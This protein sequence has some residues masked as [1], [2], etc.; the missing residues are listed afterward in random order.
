MNDI[1][2]SIRSLIKRPGFVAVAVI[3]LALGIGANTA[4]FSVI[5]AVVLR[6]LP[7]ADPDR[8]VMVWETVAGNDRRSVAP[9][10]YVDWRDQNKT[11]AGMSAAF[12]G[13]FNL[14]GD[15]EP[16]RIDG[17]TITSNLM[18]VLGVPAQV[19]RTFQPVD[20][21][22]RGSSVVLIS[23][24]LWKGR[25]G[26]DHNIIGR[27][28]TIDET[29]HTVV[30]V[31]P[32]GFQF[33][34][35]SDLWVLGRD[36]NAVSLSLIS[37]FPENDWT[38]ERDAHF[39]RVVGRL[40][41]DTSLSQ[42]Q[43][44]IAG[45]ALRAEQDFPKTNAGLGSA[46]VSLHSQVVGKVQG[47]LFILFGAVAFVLLIACTNVA[48]LMLARSVKREREIAIRVAVG[49]GR[50]RLVRQLLTESFLLSLSGG[51]AG[52]LLSTW[53]VALFIKLSPGDI[54]RLDEATVD[55]RLLA[56]TFVISLLTG[57]GFGLL[58]A[59]HSTRVRLSSSL[60]EGS[61]TTYGRLPR[62]TR[63][64]LIAS[65]I[66]L[67][68][69][70]LVGAGLL[71]LS[72]VR[73]SEVKPGF[74]TQGVLSAKIAPSAKKYPDPKAKAAFYSI[75]LARLSQLPGVRSV[76]MVMNL[77]L[78][79]ASMN[80]GFHAEGRPDPKPDENV[81]M[82]YQVVSEDYFRTLEVPMV[83]GRAFTNADT[84]VSQRVIVINQALAQ[85]YWLNEDPIGRRIA[86]GDKSKEA[87]WRTIV[88]V[89]G[90]MRHAS[91]SEHPVPT[92][93]TVYR[94][95]LES[96]PRMAF[97]LKTD[98]DQVALT[99]AVRSALISIDPSQP[100]YAIE[101][102]EKLVDD[103]IAPRRFVMSLI[104]LLAFVALVLSAVGV[105]GVISISVSERTQEMGIRMALGARKGDVLAL[106]LGQSARIAVL[107]IVVGLLGAFALT[108]LLS[109]LL[110]EVSPTDPITFASVAVL[111]GLVALVACYIPARRATKVDPLVALRYE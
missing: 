49:A 31:M 96:W 111:L 62:N 99:S 65:E 91:L 44:D 16:E 19:G 108:R 60:K 102:M 23:D 69:I 86:I 28:I 74:N 55:F 10:N 61:R 38:H 67:A 39:L 12:N 15:A 8:L 109:T 46:V 95:D 2:Y 21:S 85:R 84:D 58:P 75:V 47:L 54:P 59:F 25:F 3:T 26:A 20:D 29:P 63:N 32:A 83:R 7:Y 13:N 94:Q 11:F 88:G 51:L 27:S 89:V 14:T 43:S 22:A 66:A 33:P 90:D 17:A 35:K 24:G 52:L 45:I 40:K 81:T 42:A 76:G 107:G 105:Y 87:S 78:S 1:R 104:G 71:I 100:V 79:G 4:I 30:G 68:Q 5:N 37:Q 36:R 57:V 6:P 41:P 48:N 110:F 101:P 70:L 77:P 18:E 97:V 34:A 56:F 93:F 80:R 82:D 92:A 73:A 103:S 106:V 53:V 64:V 72:Y 9:G 98:G 50:W